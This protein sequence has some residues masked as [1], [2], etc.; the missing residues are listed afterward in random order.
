VKFIYNGDYAT[1][2]GVTFMFRNPTEV[3]NRSTIEKLL[4]DPD[5]TRCD[6]E[7]EAQAHKEV[8]EAQVLGCP[9]CGRVI[10]QGRYMHEKYCKGAQ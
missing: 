4:N 7:E 8:P 10:G 1:R 5:F 2:D 9:K 6:H 3:E